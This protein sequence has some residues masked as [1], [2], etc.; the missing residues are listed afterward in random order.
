MVVLLDVSLKSLAA[1]RCIKTAIFRFAL[2]I[3][4]LFHR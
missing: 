1:F 2:L 4:T 3:M